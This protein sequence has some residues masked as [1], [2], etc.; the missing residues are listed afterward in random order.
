MNRSLW[1]SALLLAVGCATPLPQTAPAGIPARVTAPE[2]RAGDDWKYTLHDGYTKLPRG[3]LEYRVIAVEGDTVTVQLRH[4]GRDSVER[5]TRDWNWRERP[6]TNLQNF[7][8]DPPYAALPFPLEAGKT[9]RAYVKATD[10]ATG[11]VNRVRIDGTVLGWERVKVPAGEFDA[12]KVRRLV[13]AGNHDHFLTEEQ[14]AEIDWYAPGVGRIVKHASNS[15]HYDTRIGCD[16]RFG[17]SQ[18]VNNGWNVVELV[19]PPAR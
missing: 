8:Y 15:G 11:R 10:P 19:S 5:Y 14:I 6:M 12:L 3:M 7:R 16:D 2:V 13:Y 4:E 9:W 17:C 18:W 1:L